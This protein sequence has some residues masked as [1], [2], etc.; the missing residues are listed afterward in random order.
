MTP[1]REPWTDPVAT[2]PWWQRALCALGFHGRTVAERLL[3][4]AGPARVVAFRCLRC[5]HEYDP[6]LGT[7]IAALVNDYRGEP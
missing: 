5:R 4:P 3:T 2:R 6:D 7:A 1:Y